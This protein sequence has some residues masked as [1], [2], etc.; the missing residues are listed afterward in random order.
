M[1]PQCPPIPV[2][3]PPPAFSMGFSVVNRTYHLYIRVHV[4]ARTDTCVVYGLVPRS[5][6][7]RQPMM[8]IP[9]MRSVHCAGLPRPRPHQHL[10]ATP[11]GCNQS[12]GAL[13]QR[14]LSAEL[15]PP[16]TWWH[17]CTAQNC[18]CVLQ[19]LVTNDHSKVQLLSDAP[20]YS[21]KPLV[22][23]GSRWFWCAL[24]DLCMWRIRMQK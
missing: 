10:G 1:C 16:L 19:R 7:Y 3:V 13:Q 4:Y 14:K 18:V 5:F 15:A 9:D 21:A 17:Y 6:Q 20:V 8:C 2:S 22:L 24:A 11:A 12:R 23:L